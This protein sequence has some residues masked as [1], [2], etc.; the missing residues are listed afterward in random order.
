MRFI[1][2][3]AL[4]ILL[5]SGAAT[6]AAA[7]AP[8]APICR[9]GVCDGADAAGAAERAVNPHGWVWYRKITLRVRTDAR[10]AWAS[11]E[12]G[13]PSDEVWIDRSWDAGS[14]WEG[15]LGVIKIP[16]N[17]R[18]ARTGMYHFDDPAP[19]RTGMLRAC[20]KAG[21]RPEIAC[22]PW[23]RSA[24]SPPALHRASV[25]VLMG[26]Y[27]GSKGMW[28]PGE[29]EQGIWLSANAL[30]ALI[31]YMA[32]TGDRRYYGKIAEI[33]ARHPSG[34]PRTTIEDYYDDFGW[35]A[36]AWVR[37]YDLTGEPSY[38]DKAENIATLI[39][40]QWDT[41]CGGGIRWRHSDHIKN[42]ITNALYIKL[43]ASL[44]RRQRNANWLVEAQRTWNW[45][46]NGTGGQMLAGTSP[47]LVKD[48]V[49]ENG[50]G[51][52][53]YFPPIG[54]NTYTYLQGALAGGLAE[55]YGASG[56]VALLDWAAGVANA[57]TSRLVLGSGVLYY[58][59]E[60]RD[61]G[62]KDEAN[63]YPSDGTA[64]KGVTVRNLRELYDTSVRLGRPTGNWRAF[65]LRQSESLIQDG[66]SGWTEFG[67]HWAG[68][69][70]LGRYITFGTQ[71]SAVDAFNAAYGL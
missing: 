46:R 5:S 22:T 14:T 57:A 49:Y 19:A 40:N 70:R 26:A 28:G 4:A 29:P 71:Q 55:L 7:P 1:V 2:S 11:I 18:A 59:P 3:G 39:K 25:D 56:D 63:R 30:T 31:D 12:N 48:A 38:L 45:F 8:L 42:A 41:V 20:G 47:G 35:W 21:D 24:E 51:Q 10:M 6:A 52:C 66:R 64:F 32:R 37:A 65:L 67:L 62:L 68:P 43:T 36:L 33:A 50:S 27:D 58:D 13:A 69:L 44:R 54:A 15:R 34:L 60:E 9:D 53:V 16:A 61:E 23:V 17:G